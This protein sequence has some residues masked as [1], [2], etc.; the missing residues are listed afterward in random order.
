MAKD[1][2][3]QKLPV[4]FEYDDYHAYLRDWVVER[5]AQSPGFS[6]QVLANRAGLK[7]RSFLRLVS[8]GEKDLGSATALALSEAMGHSA[9]EGEFF[10]CL[11]AFNNATDLREKGLHLSRMGKIGR[12]SRSAVLSVQQYDLFGKWF[13]APIWELVTVVDFREDYRKLASQ[14]RPAITAAEARYAVELLLE[15]GLI[16]KNGSMYTQREPSLHTRDELKSQAVKVFQEETMRLGAEALD[17]F[18]L[19]E[20]SI[21]TLTLGL[22]A[23]AWQELRDKIHAFRDDLVQMAQ[24]VKNTDRVYQVNYQAFP[25]T[26]GPLDP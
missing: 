18:P 4:V 25:L 7:S 24:Q 12:P 21:G 20:R 2:V 15:L 26:R 19:G 17:R 3:D 14:L 23:R 22:D 11:V 13:V 6:F 9:K 5:R 1:P 10:Q 16:V 8:I